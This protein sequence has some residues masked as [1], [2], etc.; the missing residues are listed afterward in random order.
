MSDSGR[1]NRQRTGALLAA[2]AAGWEG[3][4]VAA[5]TAGAQGVFLLKRC[6]D[7]ADLLAAAATG[8]AQVAV[9]SSSLPGL[10]ADSVSR[11][12]Q[13]GVQVVAVDAE[14][15]SARGATREQLSRLGIDLV[16][17]AGEL[18]ALSERVHDLVAGTPEGSEIGPPDA[19]YR[20]AASEDQHEEV[21]GLDGTGSHRGRLV[22]VWGATGAPGR[23]TVAIGL[24][25]ELAQRERRT[26]LLDADPYGGAVGLHLAVL[27]DVSGL[28]AASRLANTGQLDEQ[29][30]S[31]LARSL[32]QQLRVVTGLPRPGRW[33]EVRPAAY[34]DVLEVA[35][36]LDD[37]VVVDTGF[38]IEAG[39][40]DPFDPTPHRDEVTRAT[41]QEADLVVAVASADPVGLQRAARALL[42]LSELRP[43]GPSHVVVNRMR[44]SLGWDERDVADLIHK[45]TPQASVVFLPDDPTAVDRALVAGRTLVEVGDSPLR[46][47]LERLV[48]SLLKELGPL[49]SARSAPFEQPQELVRRG[50][51]LG[52]RAR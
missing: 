41:L 6:L 28:L 32:G 20:A 24:A 42:D 12:H 25:A 36:G 35:R 37:V 40:G 52:R 27:D 8:T 49:P 30:L 10:D 50:R 16:L 2:S 19:W 39:S 13:A 4:A 5:L 31:G 3:T 46:R 21:A 14:G 44:P 17:G 29:R 15:T 45:V 23:T 51:R 38:G 26:L 43:Q 11:L 34:A 1:L 9:V 48:D 47:T 22:A 33:T 7:L 18:T